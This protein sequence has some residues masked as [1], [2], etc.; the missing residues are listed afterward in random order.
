MQDMLNLIEGGVGEDVKY[1][2]DFMELSDEVEK[3]SSPTAADSVDFKKINQLS[4]DIL[5]NK[6]KDLFAAVYYSYS[7]IKLNPNSLKEALC[8]ISEF[9]EK[10]FENGFPKKEK[11]KFNALKWWLTKILIIIKNINPITTQDNEYFECIEKL[12]SFLSKYEEAPSLF[13]L[14]SVINQKII[15]PKQEVKEEKEVIKPVPKT[16]EEKINE[17]N[18]KEIFEKTIKKIDETLNFLIDKEYKAEYFILN[19]ISYMYDI[20]TLPMAENK[21]TLIPPP[22]NEEINSIQNLYKS[23]NYKELLEI[24]ESKIKTY[25][26]WLDL[27]FYVAKALE[28]LGFEESAE[29][30]KCIINIF[31]KKLPGIEYYS[32]ADGTPFATNE[33]KNWLKPQIKE[34]KKDDKFKLP[35]GNLKEKISFINEKILTSKDIQEKINWLIIFLENFKSDN[36]EISKI[37]A[38]E[39][40]GLL[41]KYNISKIDKELAKKAYNILLNLEIDEE[42]SKS[43]LKVLALLDATHFL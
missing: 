9:V 33:T 36:E 1:D 8:F 15:K 23:Q 21:K 43:A 14:K 4:H 25:I 30:I 34:I 12:E 7:L 38:Q 39:L 29:G 40:F 6:S 41:E 11:A 17:E 35:D 37:Y 27:H 32:F 28:N 16:E 22:S 10:F 19:R 5:I 26:F 31:I 24:C 3:L 18:A 42:I 2:D 13:E 20:T